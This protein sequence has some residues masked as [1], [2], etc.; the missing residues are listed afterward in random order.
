MAV[1]R[2]PGLVPY[3]VCAGFA[4]V[5]ANMTQLEHVVAFLSKHADGPLKN[6]VQDLQNKLIELRASIHAFLVIVCAYAICL[7]M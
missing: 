2:Q 5:S 3:I 4:D 7:T 6:I 1:S